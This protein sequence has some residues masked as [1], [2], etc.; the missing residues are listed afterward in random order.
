[1]TS[2]DEQEGVIFIMNVQ[3]GIRKVSCCGRTIG[4]VIISTTK[5]RVL[6]CYQKIQRRIMLHDK[7][8]K[9]AVPV[10]GIDQHRFN[11]PTL[12]LSA[13]S[14]YSE[15]GYV[16]YLHKQSNRMALQDG[17]MDEKQ[18]LPKDVQARAPAVETGGGKQE[19][20][21]PSVHVS[22]ISTGKCS[23]RVQSSCCCTMAIYP[24]FKNCVDAI[25]ELAGFALDQ[26]HCYGIA[27]IDIGHL[28][29]HR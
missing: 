17:K 24:M 18:C 1:M 4:R 14:P 3:L 21:S 8:R 6:D 20:G 16:N 23:D 25:C 29:T 26:A 15:T 22:Q 7:G 11:M 10:R 27:A 2:K 13:S 28:G 12:P 9:Q 19:Q 5:S